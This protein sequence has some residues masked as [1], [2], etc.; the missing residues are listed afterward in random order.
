MVKKST[1]NEGHLYYII[2]KTI[3]FCWHSQNS[4]FAIHLK[5][6]R[7]CQSKIEFENSIFSSVIF[8]SIIYHQ[9]IENLFKFG[10]KSNYIRQNCNFE[11]LPVEI[12]FEKS[13]S[14]IPNRGAA[15]HKRK[16]HRDFTFLCKSAL[17]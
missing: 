1:N 2:L 17:R 14:V 3:F 10:W 8:F 12:N 6:S 5:Y 16:F 13:K 9:T 7:E 15:A 11:L 4:W